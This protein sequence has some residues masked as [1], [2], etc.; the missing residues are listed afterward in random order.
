[1]NK[2]YDNFEK[3]SCQTN[4][5]DEK[6]GYYAF[7]ETIFYVEKG[8]MPSDVGKINGLPVIDLKIENDVVYHKVEGT[9]QNP[10][11]MEVD[12]DTR[13]F[14]TAVQSAFHIL[15]G[16]FLKKGY[17]GLSISYHPEHL[18]YETSQ[19]NISPE[20][21]EEIENYMK[22]V[23]RQ[24]VPVT[25]SYICG[26]DYPDPEYQHF[27]QVRIVKFGDLDC[28]P[29]GTLHLNRTSQIG[30]F[31]VLGVEKSQRGSRLQVAL[32]KVTNQQLR[33]EHTILK[34]VEKIFN[35]KKENLVAHLNTLKDN[36][37]A[38]K[39]ELKTLKKELLEHEMTRLLETNATVLRFEPKEQTQLQSLATMMVNQIT[40]TKII[41]GMFQ[42]SVQFAILSTTGNARDIFTS[43]KEKF[44]QVSG[45]GSPKIVTGKVE[46]YSEE[47]IITF[48]Q[49]AVE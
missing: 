6:D 17:Q 24:D 5:V 48:F 47:E 37:K 18:W 8:G 35:V 42:E 9:L 11:F 23:I 49:T 21:L 19:E 7:A 40:G 32:E 2:N 31:V 1:M 14:N 22:E 44:D 36:Q 10:I 29:C 16:Y 28:Q 13:W 3:M 33:E 20:M 39:D 27:D 15:D 45:G 30:S 25:I 46:G 12:R 4:I 43:F 26:R 38:L 41:V 34:E